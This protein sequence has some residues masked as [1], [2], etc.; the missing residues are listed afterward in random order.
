MYLQNLLK[1]FDTMNKILRFFIYAYFMFLS[2]NDAF[3]FYDWLPLYQFF[4]IPILILG[5]IKGLRFIDYKLDL[6]LLMMLIFLFISS[7]MNE[8]SKTINY[9]VA[10]SYVIFG[11]YFVFKSSLITSNVDFN[12]LLKANFYGIVLLSIYIIFEVFLKILLDFDI[13]VYL[14]RT[15]ETTATFSLGLP[16]AYGFSTEPT[17]VA[18]YLNSFA[19]LAIYYLINNFKTF[20][21]KYVLILTIICS[22]IL[23]FSSA[24]FLYLFLGLFFITI[25]YNLYRI[26]LGKIFLF[27][28]ML[29]LS[30][31]LFID[32]IYDGISYFSEGI[33]DKI[34][35]NSE[36]KSVSQ[37]VDATMIAVSRFSQSPIIGS[38]LGLTSSLG[39]MSP[40]SW[41]LILLTNGGL[42]AS[43]PFVVFSSLK[44]YQVL[45]IK[46]S[47]GIY[48][49]FSLIVSLLSLTT[50][51]I[52]FNPFLWT[53]L[54]VIGLY[55]CKIA[56]SR[57]INVL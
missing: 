44:V 11:M 33:F 51:A 47:I 16:R 55:R 54:A 39:E 4:L 12:S 56:D 9:V 38:G 2:A 15:R 20:M 13:S 27:H 41:Y 18:W 17:S 45:G 43:L 35:L 57:K 29:F 48:M 5:T 3:R 24:G 1:K 26:F 52:F 19:P 46:D 34:F 22:F 28:A 32:P 21:A 53:L 8:N 25:K 30:S 49:A 36:Y 7:A 42:L 23:T 40:M 50:T 31:I 6:L 14:Y 37:R 10:Y